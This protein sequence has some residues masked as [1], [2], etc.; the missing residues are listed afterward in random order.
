MA[1][2]IAQVVLYLDLYIHTVMWRGVTEE[3]LHSTAKRVRKFERVLLA[4][5]VFLSMLSC[6]LFVAFDLLPRIE[7]KYNDNRMFIIR[8]GMYLIIWFF[9]VLA[10]LLLM[11]ETRRNF[12]FFYE[13]NRRTLIFIICYFTLT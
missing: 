3:T 7:A 9:L 8:S 12:Y 10:L 2:S 1:A 11:H 5:F 6:V 13:Q 4:S